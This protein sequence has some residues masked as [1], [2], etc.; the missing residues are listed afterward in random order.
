MKLYDL[1]PSPNALKVRL[2]LNYLGQDFEH[3]LVD[4]AKGGHLA[5]DFVARN[6]NAKMPVL[7]DD[8][9][10]LWESNA[11]MYYLAEKHQS[12]LIPVDLKQRA[13]LH[14]WMAWAVAH[15]TPTLGPWL[16]HTMAPSFFPGFV[17]DPAVIAKAKED[18]AKY[19]AVLNQELQGKDYLLGSSLSLADLAIA[20][21]L[22]YQQLMQIDLAPYPEIGR[23]M[24]TIRKL[25][26]WDQTMAVLTPA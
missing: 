24:S 4:L 1:P 9:L 18:F 16:F 10:V 8:D 25:P 23:W 13:H 20:P 19:A 15:W 11:I 26:V 5:S 22:Q 7:E 17:P 6:P 12:D 3:E 14:K 2:V 21:L